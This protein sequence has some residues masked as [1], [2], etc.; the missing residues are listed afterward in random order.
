[1]NWADMQKEMSIAGDPAKITQLGKDVLDL[2]A[3]TIDKKNIPEYDNAVFALQRVIAELKLCR[4]IEYN[5][6]H[7]KM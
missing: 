3:N 7:P 4:K 2:T 6:Q 1:M 5:R